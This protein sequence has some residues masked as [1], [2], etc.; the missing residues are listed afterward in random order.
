MNHLVKS[1][2]VLVA[3]YLPMMPTSGYAADEQGNYFIAG[4]A[5]AMSCP[6]FLDAMASA[7]QHGGVQSASGIHYVR[8]Y[9]AYVLGF[10]TAFNLKSPGVYD[11]FAP[12]SDSG[13]AAFPALFAIEADCKDHPEKK[14][15]HALLSL[16]AKMEATLLDGQ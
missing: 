6:A 2:A 3:L 11:V 5:G 4:G 9:A 8:D 7:R 10:E 16:D 15:A 12:I 14:F 1:Y 13:S